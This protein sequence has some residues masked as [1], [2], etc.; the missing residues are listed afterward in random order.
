M[1]QLDVKNA[2]LHGLISESLYME[3]SPGM[4]DPAYPKHICKLHKA[5]YGLKQAP[6]AWF[7]RF[8]IFLL[9]Y[10][11]FCSLANP[12]LFIFHSNHQ[13]FFIF[14]FANYILSLSL[15]CYL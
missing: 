11:F 8:S 7:D 5:L 15:S 13:I 3:Q 4:A 12:S 14:F 2:F 10:G 1:H 6:R 9:K